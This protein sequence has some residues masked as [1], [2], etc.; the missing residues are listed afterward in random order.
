MRGQWNDNNKPEAPGYYS[1]MVQLAQETSRQI[2]G[3]LAMPVK[4]NWG[5]I[6]EVVEV[7][8]L[9]DLKEK[10]GTDMN[11]TAYKLG[12]IALMGEPEKLLLIRL[13]GESAKTG[14]AFLNNTAEQPQ[15][16]I[17][18][19]TL[20]PSDRDFRISVSS[21]IVETSKKDITLYEGTEVLGKIEGITGTLEEIVEEINKSA[22]GNYAKASLSE[23][24][25]G[26]LADVSSIEFIG[27]DNGTDGVSNASY[28]EAM[29]TFKAYEIDGFT[30]DGISDPALIISTIAWAKECK[31]EGLDF[32]VFTATNENTL[33]A[34]NQKSKAYNSPLIHNGFAR[35]LVYDNVEYSIA[36]AM[37]YVAALALSK[38]LKGSICNELTIFTDVQPRLTIPEVQS[39]LKAGT[40]VFTMDNKAGKVRIVDDVNT[41]KEFKKPEEEVL[42]CIRANKFINTVN[43][44]SYD[45]SV[46]EFIGQVSGD[47]TGHTIILSGYKNFFDEWKK[48]GIINGY[49][50]GTDEEYQKNAKT[51]EYFWKWSAGYVNVTKRIYSTGNL[52]G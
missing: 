48:Q 51:E 33:T 18:L 13:A 1:R 45:K 37:V 31:K 20:Y 40:I 9:P 24:A 29:N 12:R 52:V 44:V 16:V 8:N 42:G 15:E 3:V 39:A 25:S 38:D 17:W 49:T 34:A 50:V 22:I 46:A 23:G 28:L 26:E 21:N 5:P 47:D 7:K 11:F 30:L 2:S 6:N 41:Y 36:E 4:G 35:K 27:G 14:K 32:L 19:E 10:F 43:K